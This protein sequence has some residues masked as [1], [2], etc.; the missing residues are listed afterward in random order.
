MPKS[1]ASG[2]SQAGVSGQVVM[3]DGR[4]DTLNTGTPPIFDPVFADTSQIPS[5]N[6][7]KAWTAPLY[8]PVGST[9]LSTAGT[10]FL[11]RIKR[12]PATSIT[13]IV[14]YVAVAGS[15]LTAGQ[16]F[17]ALFTAAGALVGQSA[18]QAAAWASTGLKTMALTS[19]PYNVAAGDYYVGVWF[20]G[21]TGPTLLRGAAIASGLTNAGLV[22]PNLSACTADTGLTTTAP[23]PFGAQSGTGAEFW[24]AL[25]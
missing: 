13:N 25:S 7:F 9:V 24:Y 21:T 8:M 10:L 5:D 2:A 3:A 17:A 22:A 4:V 16:C 15:S 23:N 12:V 20:N 19:G 14:A 18:D 11:R 1:N 6:G